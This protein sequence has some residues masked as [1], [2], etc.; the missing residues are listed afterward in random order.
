MFN[1]GTLFQKPYESGYGRF[2]R[3]LAANHSTDTSNAK[4]TE[5]L[6]QMLGKDSWSVPSTVAVRP[7]KASLLQANESRFSSSATPANVREMSYVLRKNSSIGHH[8][9][10]C[11]RINFHTDIFNLYW[12]NICPV[13][14]TKLVSTC[15][16]CGGPWLPCS[17]LHKSECLTCGTNL[18]FSKW[19][20]LDT[21]AAEVFDTALTPH[22]QFETYLDSERFPSIHIEGLNTRWELRSIH[23]NRLTQLSIESLRFYGRMPA[24]LKSFFNQGLPYKPILDTISLDLESL[25]QVQNRYVFPRS[26]NLNVD[27]EQLRI[28]TKHAFEHLINKSHTLGECDSL[29]TLCIYCAAWNS[30]LTVFGY[31]FNLDWDVSLKDWV[32]EFRNIQHVKLSITPPILPTRLARINKKDYLLP[33]SVSERLNQVVGIQFLLN[34]LVQLSC[35]RCYFE[36]YPKPNQK[37]YRQMLYDLE[38]HDA[39]KDVEFG[40]IEVEGQIKLCWFKLGI[41]DN[42]LRKVIPAQ[43]DDFLYT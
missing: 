6:V 7:Y 23:C 3:F 12:V 43:R 27:F 19:V 10:D 20:E 4:I 30:W 11:A 15:P 13:H 21:I 39:L 14:G 42:I 34:L 1:N 32:T 24:N 31:K 18:S 29:K 41:P 8:C 33:I 2:C 26:L 35:Q 16:D 38:G 28:E 36:A 9:P 17:Q 37:V 22:F 40:A 25:E 5:A